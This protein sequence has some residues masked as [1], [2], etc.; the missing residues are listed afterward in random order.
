MKIKQIPSPSQRGLSK[1]SRDFAHDGLGE[2]QGQGEEQEKKSAKGSD[3]SASEFP[4]HE[5]EEA[6]GRGQEE[7][8]EP[9]RRGLADAEEKEA[10]RDQQGIAC[11]GWVSLVG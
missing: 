1:A 2:R 11:G 10:E 4:P 8:I 9:I 7:V 6:H 5:K 3:P